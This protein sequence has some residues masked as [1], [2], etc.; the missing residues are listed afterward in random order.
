VTAVTRNV[1]PIDKIESE[2]APILS[3]SDLLDRLILAAD[4]NVADVSG[5]IGRPAI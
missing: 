2:G 3:S 1:A 5:G 4:G